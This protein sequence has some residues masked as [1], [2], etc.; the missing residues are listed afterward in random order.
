MPL[1]PPL[2]VR[3]RRPMRSAV[4]GMALLPL[5]AAAGFAADATPAQL[6]ADY[7]H[8]VRIARVDLAAGSAE[9]LLAGS[10]SEQLLAAV[11]RGDYRDYART[12]DQ[13]EKIADLAEVTQ[14]LRRRVQAA[15]IERARDKDRI[16]AD[17]KALAASPRQRHNAIERLTAAG[18][19][20]AP[21]MLDTLADQDQSALH[22]HLET[23]MV[24]IGRS[25]VYPLSV[26]LRE[27]EPVT[28]SQVARILAEIGYPRA[29]PYLGEALEDESISPAARRVLQSAYDQLATA[30]G[31]PADVTAAELFRT[32]AENCY[33]GGTRG[34]LLP[35]F[36]EATDRGIVWTFDRDAGL[37][38]IPVPAPV[39]PD[40]LAM[41]AARRA[42]ALDARMDP[43]LSIWLAANSRR[44]NRLPAGKQDDSY[45]CLR[46]PTYYLRMAGPLRQHDV[47]DRALRVGDADLALDAIDA[48]RATAGTDA[49]INRQGTIQPLLRALSYPDR[50]VRFPAAFAMTR[51][52]PTSPFPGSHRV[53]SVLAEAVRQSDLRHALVIADE[54]AL[55]NR[56]MSDL[57]AQG[58]NVTGGLSLEAVSDVVASGPGFDVIVTAL[59]PANFDAALVEFRRHY[60]LAAV[61]VLAV[62]REDV[63]SAL[64]RRHARIPL[65][66]SAPL[67]SGGHIPD[68]AVAAAAASAV[69][70]PIDAEEAAGYALTALELLRDV[71]LGDGVVYGA[72]DAE[73]ALIAALQDPRDDI[74]MQAGNVLE[75]LN[76][77]AAQL[78]VAEAALDDVRLEDVRVSLLD[79]L[80]ESARQFGS[81]LG[82]IQLDQLLALVRDS[83]GPL[84]LAA[85]RA[86][87]A[88][89]LPTSNVVQLILE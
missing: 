49:L 15:R 32:L 54:Q 31:V 4:W 47:L 89:T 9:A 55:L 70:A 53:V 33:R 40:V 19:F 50:R 38:P 30:A 65:F 26:A 7:N 6:W 82:Q 46:E 57:G 71:A 75:L 72:S 56:V 37:A 86:H 83:E 48:L 88:L 41:R 10:D 1:S 24:T 85:A 43:A 18:Q 62:G 64:Q 2:A 29:L 13:A 3:T 81:K 44:E 74:V 12:F 28:M 27:L 84:A 76:S 21:Q 20:A 68:D 58:Y 42:L 52:R 14:Q 35:G 23:A 77:Q 87:G 22:P 34:S 11:E 36:D 67:D 69:G 59:A 61:P 80:A 60:K 5:V 39:F 8:Y 73:P 45:A 79:S 63:V 17:I 78:A 16:A 51:T 66:H 25:L